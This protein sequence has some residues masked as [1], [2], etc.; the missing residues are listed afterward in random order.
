MKTLVILLLLSA[1]AFATPFDDF[2][3]K[4]SP[5]DRLLVDEALN[6]VR[7]DCAAQLQ[8]LTVAR[9]ADAT[10]KA[11]EIAKHQAAAD[12]AKAALDA[13]SDD[14]KKADALAKIEEAKTPAKDAKK[15]ELDKQISALQAE[16]AKLDTAKAAE[17]AAKK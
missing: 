13:P 1:A 15:A 6:D 4:L 9:D 14:A 8:T 12:A 5:E 16:R 10:A 7:R 3:L 2:R 11:T 17:A